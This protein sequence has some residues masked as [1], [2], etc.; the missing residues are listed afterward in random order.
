MGGARAQPIRLKPK[1]K[2]K[3]EGKYKLK[4]HKGALKRFYQQGDG[5]FVHKAS[6]KKHLQAG[7]SRR[8]Q[9]LRK[10]AHRVVAAPGIVKKLRRL[11][12]YGTTLQPSTRF[13]VSVLWERPDDWRE[14][15]QAAVQ[16]AAQAGATGKQKPKGKAKANAAN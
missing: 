1:L 9:T 15:V 2:R 16:K 4:S 7:T 11:M 6:G 3:P 5:T 8:R 13:K 14:T 12:P 10:M